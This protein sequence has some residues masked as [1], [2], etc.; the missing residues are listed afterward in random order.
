MK[1]SL[2]A[3]RTL[4]LA[5]IAAFFLLPVAAEAVPQFAAG[6]YTFKSDVVYILTPVLGLCIIGA[7]VAAWMGKISWNW[8]GGLVLGTILVFGSDQIVN[9]LRSAFTV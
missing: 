6:G 2:L 8:F 1:S 9:W 5:I 7:G 3:G 4:M